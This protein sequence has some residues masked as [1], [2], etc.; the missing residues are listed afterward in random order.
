MKRNAL[1]MAV[2]LVALTVGVASARGVNLFWNDCSPAAGGAGVSDQA[3]DCTSN[4]GAFILIASLVPGP[5]ITQCVGA[6][7]VIDIQSAVPTL[8]PWWQMRA[9]DGCRWTSFT[10]QFTFFPLASC[11]DPWN[12]QALGAQDY[13]YGP[14]LPSR[15]RLR[16]VCAVPE[17]DA[18]PLTPDHEYYIFQITLDKKKSVG[19]GSC[20]GCSDAACFVLSSIKISQPTGNPGGDPRYDYDPDQSMFATYNGAASALCEATPTRNRTWG[21]IKAIYR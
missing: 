5:G 12:G 10:T 1:L 11:G 14:S 20:A 3:N 17:A 18:A 19:A 16:M 8:S 9:P 15:A 2:V 13:S 4:A 6:E 21:A 7:G